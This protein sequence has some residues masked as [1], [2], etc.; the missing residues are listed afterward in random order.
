MQ[1]AQKFRLLSNE[2]LHLPKNR[3]PVEESSTG[4]NASGKA[5]SQDCWLCPSRD[6]TKQECSAGP[7]QMDLS[8]TQVHWS[9]SFQL[10]HAKALCPL[11]GILPRKREKSAHASALDEAQRCDP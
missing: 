5:A 3:G 11:A 2:R 10:Q 6:R 1:R 4:A 7:P 9:G 8:L